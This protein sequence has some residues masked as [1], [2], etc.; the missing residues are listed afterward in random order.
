MEENFSHRLINE[1]AE[2][3]A[4]NPIRMKRPWQTSII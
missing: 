4:H 1:F 3:E 2:I